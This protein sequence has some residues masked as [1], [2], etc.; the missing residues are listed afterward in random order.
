VE[1]VSEYQNMANAGEDGGLAQKETWSGNWM[2]QN[3]L[4]KPWI[5]PTWIGKALYGLWKWQEASALAAHAEIS[6]SCLSEGPANN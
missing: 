6:T 3:V 2:V 5:P 1:E 4:A